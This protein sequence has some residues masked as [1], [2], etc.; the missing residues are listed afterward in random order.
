MV[1]DTEVPKYLQ[2]GA[3]GKGS[4]I[5]FESDDDLKWCILPKPEQFVGKDKSASCTDPEIFAMRIVLSLRLTDLVLKA[6]AI[7]SEFNEPKP[8]KLFMTSLLIGFFKGQHCKNY[9]IIYNNS[10]SLKIRFAFGKK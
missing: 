5:H 6:S 4:L 8:F 1:S 7:L 3:I 2:A 10:Q 9:N